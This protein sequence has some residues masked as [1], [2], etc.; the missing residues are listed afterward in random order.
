MPGL[1]K[2]KKRL[3]DEQ[4]KQP[5]QPKKKTRYDNIVYAYGSN[6]GKRAPQGTEANGDMFVRYGTYKD[7]QIIDVRTSRKTQHQEDGI[8]YVRRS[9]LHHW[10]IV[11]IQTDK[12]MPS[13]TPPNGHS[14]IKAPLFRKTKISEERLKNYQAW[15]AKFYAHR[16]YK[17]PL[18]IP[19]NENHHQEEKQSINEQPEKEMSRTSSNNTLAAHSEP[20][21]KKKKLDDGKKACYGDVSS[22]ED[23]MEIKSETTDTLNNNF[24]QANELS[25][26]DVTKA[27]GCI[28]LPP[29]ENES[30][31]EM[32]IEPSVVP[33]ITNQANSKHSS[34]QQSTMST[35]LKNHPLWSIVMASGLEKSS[36]KNADDM[37]EASDDTATLSTNLT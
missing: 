36:P 33:E 17:P 6:A 37:E 22:D 16:D 24:K 10:A 4:P 7:H 14:L 2:P 25:S 19:L 31:Y 23:I 27:S 35:S 1:P 13:G 28:P 29:I 21:P 11:N 5:K 3:R 26:S 15:K 9:L 12:R 32:A 18:G 8:M 34:Y 30:A 20:S